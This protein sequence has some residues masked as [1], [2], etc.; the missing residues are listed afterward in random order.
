MLNLRNFDNYQIIFF[1]KYTQLK[2]FPCKLYSYNN[3]CNKFET[4]SFNSDDY[5]NIH[6]QML[7]N[8]H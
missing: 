4:P 7:H 2:L 5:I 6:V 3:L 8:I 1:F